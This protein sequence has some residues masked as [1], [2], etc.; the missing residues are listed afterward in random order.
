MKRERGFS[1]LELVVVMMIVAA[2]FVGIAS[3][4]GSNVRSLD[5]NEI[6]QQATQ[7][8]QYCTERAMQQRRDSGYA[9]FP[10]NF[11][12]SANPNTSPAACGTGQIG[13][14]CGAFVSATYTGGADTACPSGVSCRDV[15]ITAT[16]AASGLNASISL[17]L[18]N[19]L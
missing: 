14:S 17:M 13:F 1:L 3:L 6:V 9:A 10:A 11:S 8:A 15:T 7:H 18:A 4:L 16:H 5:A 19:Y 12:C 2:G